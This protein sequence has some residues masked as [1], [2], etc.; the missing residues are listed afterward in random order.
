MMKSRIEL[1][2]D[3]SF[4]PLCRRKLTIKLKLFGNKTI[5]CHFSFLHHIKPFFVLASSSLSS[6]HMGG[7]LQIACL[8]LKDPRKP[9]NVIIRNLYSLTDN[10]LVASKIDFAFL[11]GWSYEDCINIKTFFFC[12]CFWAIVSSIFSSSNRLFLFVNHFWSSNLQVNINH[13]L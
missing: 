1:R 9:S 8:L 2:H 10:V 7:Q 12:F 5:I 13:I 3:F 4:W 11:W 6:L